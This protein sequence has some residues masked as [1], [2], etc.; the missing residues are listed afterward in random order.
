M[1]ATVKPAKKT[2]ASG[3][4]KTAKVRVKTERKKKT[5]PDLV[6][7]KFAIFRGEDAKDVWSGN[8]FTPVFNG[9]ISADLFATKDE[10]L[11]RL[12]AER[13]DAEAIGDKENEDAFVAPAAKYLATHYDISLI[14]IKIAF[15]VTERS[16]GNSFKSE[17]KSMVKEL[18][19][20]VKTAQSNL[21]RAIKEGH[22]EIAK[23]VS[24][25]ARREREKR[26]QLAAA[27]KDA[28]AFEKKMAAYQ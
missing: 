28:L 10:A 23:V 17:I 11:A 5:I 15:C 4:R 7:G 2:K 25:T 16:A 26:S 22:T 19:A 12:A 6:K 13:A 14:P 18:S 27:V 20:S 8:T 9:A 24:D 3:K 21:K 1:P